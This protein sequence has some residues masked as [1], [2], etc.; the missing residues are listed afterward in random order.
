MYR[1]IEPPGPAVVLTDAEFESVV[2][3]MARL[4][5]MYTAPGADVLV[6]PARLREYGDQRVLTRDRIQ[7]V[8]LTRQCSF[9][10]VYPPPGIVGRF[11]AWSAQRVVDYEECWQ[12]GAFFSYTFQHAR[13]D[14][15]LYESTFEEDH[16]DGT[17]C[18]FAG[19]VL[20][21]QGPPPQ[22]AEVLAEL[23]ASLD[24]LVSH[25][26]HGYPGLTGL[27]Y[28]R[29]AEK[30]ESSLLVGLRSTLDNVGNLG[31]VA[32]RMEVAAG[33]MEVVAGSLEE[34]ARKL[35]GIV[36]QLLE[37]KLLAAT[38]EQGEYPRL[39]LVRPE[40]E[41]ENEGGGTHER[42]QR[43]GWDRWTSAL[44]DITLHKFRLHFLCEHDLSEVPCGPDGRGFPIEQPKD[45]VKQWLP[46]M[47][48]PFELEFLL[49]FGGCAFVRRSVRAPR[50]QDFD[51]CML[52]FFSALAR[53]TS[54]ARRHRIADR[55]LFRWSRA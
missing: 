19:L 28:F 37:Q 21:I 27:M 47:Q 31:N 41:L 50:R 49:L 38:D 14:V 20:G 15:F 40:L 6:V 12:H 1:K 11:L 10:Q 24:K 34:T 16:E 30:I 45:W 4:L 48:V 32:E 8:V 42:I 39:V 17:R 51:C 29:P 26:I 13:Y 5:V 25:K 53:C 46:L 23:T 55:P 3:T 22:A 2:S 9:G 43:A 52:R 18:M 33:R 54:Y 44:S 36:T 35:G 7:D